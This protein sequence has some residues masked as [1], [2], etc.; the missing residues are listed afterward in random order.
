MYEYPFTLPPYYT[1]VIRCLG[2]LEGVAL[3]VDLP[4]PSTRTRTRTRTCTPHPAPHPAP[5][6]YPYSPN[7]HPPP[8]VDSSFAIVKDAYPYIAQR[9]LTDPSPELQSALTKLIFGQDGKLR[10]GY[11]EALVENAADSSA[12]QI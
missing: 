9:L 7:L 5:L 8:Q 12:Y 10:W 3:Q 4:Y 1:A 6:P 2:V 11:L